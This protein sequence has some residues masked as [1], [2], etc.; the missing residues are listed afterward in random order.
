MTTSSSTSNDQ[1]SLQRDPSQWKTGDEP[2]TAAQRS[3]LAT[4]AEAA[5]EPAPTGLTKAEAAQRIE[6]LRRKTGR[7]SASAEGQAASS[8]SAV[9]PTVKAP[10]NWIT[11][12]EPMTAAQRSYLH[13]LSQEAGEPL[14]ENLTKARASQRI[15][16]LRRKIGRATTDNAGP[17][18]A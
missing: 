14:D 10:D 12:D 2:M 5:G 16:E 1:E 6:A 17:D 7:G 8:D 4:L 13:T 18:R 9:S 11:G 3:Y 15:D